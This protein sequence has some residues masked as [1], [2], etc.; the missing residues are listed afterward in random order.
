MPK[1]ELCSSLAH[2]TSLILIHIR[3]NAHV[4]ALEIAVSV[5]TDAADLQF[6]LYLIGEKIAE[7]PCARELNIPV[8]ILFLGFG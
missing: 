1:G 3:D 8:G 2:L 6:L 7:N 4:A 5:G